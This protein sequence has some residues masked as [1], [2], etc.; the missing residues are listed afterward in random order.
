MPPLHP[1]LPPSPRRPGLLP[2]PACLA[3]ISLCP[4]LLLSGVC[5]RLPLPWTGL[6]CPRCAGRGRHHHSDPGMQ[7]AGLALCY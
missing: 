4:Q 3:L 1:P 6:L 7:G 5:G 2:L